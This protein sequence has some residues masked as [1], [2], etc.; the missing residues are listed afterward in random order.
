L[1]CFDKRVIFLFRFEFQ[2]LY[3]MFYQCCFCCVVVVALFWP[4]LLDGT[5]LLATRSSP[6]EM[7]ERERE[8]EITI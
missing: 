6:S 3:I 1:F 2:K 5:F 7:R 8:R 4:S